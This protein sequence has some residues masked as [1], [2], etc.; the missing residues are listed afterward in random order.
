MSDSELETR[1]RRYWQQVWSEGDVSFLAEFYAPRFRE[2]DD[3]LTPAEFGGHVTRWREKFPDFTVTVDRVW[4]WPGGIASRVTYAG[5][6]LGDFTT[7]PATGRRTRSGGLDVFE[8]DGG[9][10]VQHWHETDHYDLFTQLGA[11]L[12]AGDRA[13]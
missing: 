1:V 6:H 3:E 7:L 5:T 10:V 13:P 11:R 12:V 2:N 4:G 8:F 9:R